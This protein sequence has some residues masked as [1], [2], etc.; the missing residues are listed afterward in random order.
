MKKFL[1]ILGLLFFS[2]GVFC[3]WFIPRAW[4]GI[5]EEDMKLAKFEA[6]E[7]GKDWDAGKVA[8][9]LAEKGIVDS[10]VGYRIYAAVDS[11]ARRSK[12]G[13]YRFLAPE[14]YR[15]IARSLALGPAR[16]EVTLKVIEGWALV[17]IGRML[18]EQSV[19]AEDF[20]RE[21]GEPLDNAACAPNWRDEYPFLA[22][23]PASASLEG[24]LFPDTY[25]VWKDQLPQ[26]LIKKQLDEFGERADKLSAEAKTQGRTLEDVVILASIVQDE[27]RNKADMATA[28]GIFMNRLNDGMP[29]QSDATINYITKSGRDRSTATDLN[30]DSPF[31]TY[32]YKGLTPAPISNPGDDALEAALHPAQTEYRYFLTDKEGKTYYAKT[33][34]EHNQNK[35]K[36]F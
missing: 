16:E 14:S 3:A 9:V 29:L 21:V 12:P 20:V 28:A 34:E 15:F 8:N 4:L 6:V 18:A 19:K 31:N 24:Y 2:F 30:I 17:D 27:V 10:V 36:A 13:T 11:S 22:E 5:R 1:L 23:L 25:R 26:S 33:L 35:Q 32:K 7:I